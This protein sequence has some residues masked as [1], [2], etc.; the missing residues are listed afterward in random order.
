MGEAQRL[1][2]ET[3]NL[4]SV[5]STLPAVP[6]EMEVIRRSCTEENRSALFILL[7][8]PADTPYQ[9]PKLSA[10][11]GDDFYK[12]RSD[13]YIH[14]KYHNIALLYLPGMIFHQR[15]LDHCY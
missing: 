9:A 11:I 4:G 10:R 15:M 1:V 6:V 13:K 14:K 7:K 8:N 2:S 5:D 3:I 12:L